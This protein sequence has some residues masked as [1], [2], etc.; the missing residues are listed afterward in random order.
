MEEEEIIEKL[1]EALGE[2][3]FEFEY[4]DEKKQII[5]ASYHHWSGR[6]IC[7]LVDRN[8]NTIIKG[9]S[10]V[11]SYIEEYRQF[12]VSIDSD[13]FDEAL[14][15]YYALSGNTYN[16]VINI[17]GEIL[18]EPQ[19]NDIY[20]DDEEKAYEVRTGKFLKAENLKQLR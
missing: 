7:A 13:Y 16:M 17:R 12:V 3:V 15:A 18:I 11:G 14:V 9:I 10:S 1:N 6:E 5:S 8:F 19:L 4:K 2:D 20:Y